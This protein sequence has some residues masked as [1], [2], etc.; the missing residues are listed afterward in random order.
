MAIGYLVF[1]PLFGHEPKQ[2][3][4]LLTNYFESI[5]TSVCIYTPVHNTMQN[6]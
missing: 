3:Q 1:G 2:C 6:S 4:W 5:T